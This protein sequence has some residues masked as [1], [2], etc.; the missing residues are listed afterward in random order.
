MSNDEP[1]TFTTQFPT[2]VPGTRYVEFHPTVTVCVD[3]DGKVTWAIMDWIASALDENDEHY[4]VI[5]PNDDPDDET[6]VYPAV[7]D[8]ERIATIAGEWLDKQVATG[9]LTP[10][11]VFY[12]A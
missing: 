5:D 10:N 1:I 11:G 12:R 4:P 3:A 2:P 6:G 9:N 7:P 8:A